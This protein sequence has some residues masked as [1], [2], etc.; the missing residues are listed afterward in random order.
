MGRSN[1]FATLIL[2]ETDDLATTRRDESVEQ[3]NL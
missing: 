1:S 3:H 2:T